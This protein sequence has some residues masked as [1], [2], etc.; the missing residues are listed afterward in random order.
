M[1]QP[2]QNKNPNWPTGNA[3]RVQINKRNPRID[4]DSM[5][6]N[7]FKLIPLGVHGWSDGLDGRRSSG[8]SNL[9]SAIGRWRTNGV[10]ERLDRQIRSKEGTVITVTTTTTTNTRELFNGERASELANNKSQNGDNKKKRRDLIRSFFLLFF[11]LFFK[12]VWEFRRS[13]A[14]R[15]VRVWERDRQERDKGARFACDMIDMFDVR[16]R[17]GKEGLFFWVVRTAKQIYF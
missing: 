16:K 15:N 13:S 11:F 10:R 9:P 5:E 2:R 8:R 17:K 12:I 4:S 14:F 6:S 3:G 1:D 7:K